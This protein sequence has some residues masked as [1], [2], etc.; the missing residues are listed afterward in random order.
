M[1]HADDTRDREAHAIIGGNQQG[2]SSLVK[3]LIEKAYDKR[4]QKVVVL[5][6]S[7]PKAFQGYF[8][9]SSKTQLMRKWNGIVRY[10]NPAGYKETLEDIYSLAT[11]GYLKNGAVIFDD[12]TK[13]IASNPPEKI[14]EFLVDR[15]MF[16]L[17]LYFTTH[18]LVMLSAWIRR[19]VNTITVFK[20]A[21]SF[22]QP[23]ELKELQYP[24]YKALFQIWTEVKNTPQT[25]E[26]IQ[27]NLTIATGV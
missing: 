4:S 26:H 11:E 17:D 6:S 9:A 21:E 15:A 16:D 1:L 19:M 18:S 23:R 3:K 25:K 22:E 2:K 12:C 7:N 20:T 24:N 5:N 10:H 13:Y 14:K 27:P 8:F